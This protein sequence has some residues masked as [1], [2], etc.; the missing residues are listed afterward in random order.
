MI[1]GY[2]VCFCVCC[3][4]GEEHHVDREW[5]PYPYLRLRNKVQ[6][7]NVAC[8]VSPE[9]VYSRHGNTSEEKKNTGVKNFICESL[10]LTSCYL[11]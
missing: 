10:Y 1:D 2:N 6:R 9:I 8:Q 5:I 4:V 7:E 11:K 3:T